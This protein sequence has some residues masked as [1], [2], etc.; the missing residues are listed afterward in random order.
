MYAFIIYFIYKICLLIKFAP[1]PFSILKTLIYTDLPL[2][3]PICRPWT[4][5][6]STVFM[7]IVSSY[8]YERLIRSISTPFCLSNICTHY[9]YLYFYAPFI[10]PLYSYSLFSSPLS[11][12]LLLIRSI[13]TYIRTP[14][15]LLPLFLLPTTLPSICTHNMYTFFSKNFPKKI[16]TPKAYPKIFTYY[17][18]SS[19]LLFNRKV[20]S[21]YSFYKILNTKFWRLYETIKTNEKNYYNFRRTKNPLLSECIL[22]RLSISFG[23]PITVEAEAYLARV[24]RFS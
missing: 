1:D 23:V 15:F 19:P 20:N 12:S 24:R 17:N 7:Q 8:N 13:R 22:S 10:Y 5:L 4:S 6:G 9:L 3:I 21:S 14:L 2:P 11:L 18:Y 16:S